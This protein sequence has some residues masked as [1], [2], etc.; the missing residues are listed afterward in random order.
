[1]TRK[2]KFKDEESFNNFISKHPYL[3]GILFW[4]REFEVDYDEDFGRIYNIQDV[5]GDWHTTQFGS[6]FFSYGD[7]KSSLIEIYDCEYRNKYGMTREEYWDEVMR[8]RQ[9]EYCELDRLNMIGSYFF[10][11]EEYKDSHYDGKLSVFLS[12]AKRPYGNK[13]IQQ[14]IAYTLGWDWGRELCYDMKGLPDNVKEAATQLHE[15]LIA[16]VREKENNEE[17]ERNNTNK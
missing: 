10:H 11:E 12:E 3:K 9:P 2:F 7:I 15:K 14:S 5:F 13:N 16:Q 1:M 17:R 8:R 4:F 6:P